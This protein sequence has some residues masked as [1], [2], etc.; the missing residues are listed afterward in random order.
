MLT[1]AVAHSL[2]QS[3]GFSAYSGE[4]TAALECWKGEDKAVGAR[5]AKLKSKNSGMTEEEAV[6]AQQKLFADAAARCYA[7]GG[8]PPD[9][10]NA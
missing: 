2:A 8:A 9:A 4:V 6:A 1:R 10:A 7:A 3:L 5:R